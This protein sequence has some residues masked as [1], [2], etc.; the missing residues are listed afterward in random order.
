MSSATKN[1][2]TKFSIK[3]VARDYIFGRY[4]HAS[5]SEKEK[6]VRDWESKVEAGTGVASDF[7]RRVGNIQ[8]EKILDAGCGNGGISIAFASAGAEVT[9]VEVEE[10]LYNI[11]IQHA[12]LHD[13]RVNFLL[14]DGGRL[15]LQDNSFD[16]AVSTSVLEHTSDPVLYL[17]EI[18]RVLRP[19]G[20]LYLTFPNKLWPKETHTGL[21][22]LT[23]IPSVFRSYMIKLFRRNPLEDNNLHFYSYGDLENMI[24]QCVLNQYRWKIVTEEGETRN[25]VKIII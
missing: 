15:P 12:K 22:F 13:L 4:P 18:L 2:S 25:K 19:G 21:W 5:I 6:Y 8:G 3:E 24:Q 23:Y 11:S 10:E 16:A 20:S 9:G 14:Y 7:V 1:N 17:E